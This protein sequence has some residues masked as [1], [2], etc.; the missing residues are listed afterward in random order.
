MPYIDKFYDAMRASALETKDHIR[1][2]GKLQRFH[3][4]GDKRGS[5][6][7]WCIF[8]PGD[9]PAGVF[10]SWKTGQR[11]TWL[12]NDHRKLTKAERHYLN[13]QIKAA[14]E[15]AEK[16]RRA[17]HVEG[18][19][20]AQRHWAQATPADANHPYLLS[21]HV[22]THGLRQRSELLLVPLYD[23]EGQLWNIQC[24]A[25][26]GNK[27]FRAGRASGLFSPIG[28]FSQPIEIIICEGWA[29]GATLHEE[30][31]LPVLCAMN[32]GNLVPVAKGVRTKWPNTALIIAADNDRTTSGN[33]GLT[34]AKEAA[35]LTV[36]RLAIPEF[37]E[38]VPG[39]DFNDL[40][41]EISK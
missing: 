4:T 11:E 9:R 6:N 26:D 37:P 2:D 16:E 12:C 21:K 29:T 13:Q 10:G 38:G 30:T 40:M 22:Q 1:S 35:R 5:L 18:A 25:P 27:R 19:K 7:G 28:N 17:A 8:F 31:G 23:I 24:I 39:T 33:P 41:L 34:K 15:Q 20:Q 32:A 14:K 3:V 36:A